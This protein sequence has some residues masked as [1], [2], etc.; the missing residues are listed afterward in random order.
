LIDRVVGLTD[1]LILSRADETFARTLAPL[2]DVPRDALVDWLHGRQLDL[3]Y[4][5]TL[6]QLIA[7]HVMVLLICGLAWSSTPASVVI[8][9]AV[10]IGVGLG[11][12]VLLSVAY[13]RS[14]PTRADR[15][16]WV[17]RYMVGLNAC[18][19][20]WACAAWLLVPESTPL[21]AALLVT[22]AIVMAGGAAQQHAYLPAAFSFQLTVASVIA[23]GLIAR[24]EPHYLFLAVG[25]AMLGACISAANASV[26]R[27][28]TRSALLNR[29]LEVQLDIS[30]KDR[31][32]LEVAKADLE[33]ANAAKSRFLAAAS[34]DL[35]QPMHAIGLLVGAM[36]MQDFAAR[37]ARRLDLL[38]QSVDALEG[39]FAGILDVSRFDA[40]SV[41][42]EVRQLKLD[43]VLERVVLQFEPVATASGLRLEWQPTR[44][45][46]EVDEML[47]DRVVRNL[48]SN[49]LRYT[50]SGR[51][52]V[53]GRRRTGDRLSIQVWDSGIGI[54]RQ[55]RS[56]IF[57][58]FV[59][60]DNPQ[61]DRSRGVGLGLSIARRCARLLQSDVVVRS[62]PGRGSLFHFSV[63]LIRFEHDTTAAPAESI[64]P[65]P[66]GLFVVL[67]EDEELVR[68]ATKDL[69][70]GMGCTSL[71]ADSLPHAL[72][73]LD[74]HLRIPDLLI[75][76]YWLGPAGDGLDA[77]RAIREQQMETVP[78]IL[79][80]GDIS[81][82][83]EGIAGLPDVAVAHK[84][85]TA[86]RLAEVMLKATRGQMRSFS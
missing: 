73:Q 23:A 11:Y 6:A 10:A 9:W 30:E 47:V 59:Q 28:V 75:C 71:V 62:R 86:R 46:V 74:K 70:E 29:A 12:G 78:A 77:I 8:L 15:P 44:A 45:I 51:V 39:L 43:Q 2:R 38:E 82:P 79:V 84:P 69:L 36:R 34:H 33:H 40:R 7:A 24:S 4:R 50:R 67:V 54:A 80:T 56:Q 27:A 60:L 61:R 72:A 68:N 66:Q 19:A 22:L 76:D 81:P 58:E 65:V 5:G 13:Q 16:R 17:L 18:G 49:A 64:A 25:F 63:K 21:Q 42:P 3:I 85:L 52:V 41:V 48:V 14:A 1:R 31:R 35:R 37:D 57:E 26:N 20:L 83:L 55:H 32:A 53:R